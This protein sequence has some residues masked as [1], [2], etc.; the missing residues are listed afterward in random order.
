[1]DARK[2][3]LLSRLGRVI[4]YTGG[5][6]DK[7]ISG[8]LAVGGRLGGRACPLIPGITVV[9]P[10]ILISGVAAEGMLMRS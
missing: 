7:A 5:H 9:S 6:D 4:Y 3:T 8:T 2:L 10:T 1:M